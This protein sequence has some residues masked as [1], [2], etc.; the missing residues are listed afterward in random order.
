MTVICDSFIKKLRTLKQYT[1]VSENTRHLIVVTKI[2]LPI[3]YVVKK[4]FQ[5]VT[6]VKMT[7]VQFVFAITDDKNDEALTPLHSCRTPILQMDNGKIA[8]AK[9]DEE[10]KNFV[11][12]TVQELIPFK[13]NIKYEDLV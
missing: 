3:E 4:T 9:L 13:K 2:K 8:Q 5:T 10:I 7:Y 12:Q 6:N 1:I 11:V